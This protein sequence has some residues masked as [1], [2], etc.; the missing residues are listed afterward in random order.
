MLGH[1][2]AR[3]ICLHE[4]L[5][6]FAQGFDGIKRPNPEYLFLESLEKPLDHTVSF[7]LPDKRWR[8]FKPEESDFVLKVF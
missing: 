1:H 5:N 3:I 4:R 2:P 6:G 7:G 8:R